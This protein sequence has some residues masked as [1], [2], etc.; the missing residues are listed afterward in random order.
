MNPNIIDLSCSMMFALC[1]A[2]HEVR[3]HGQVLGNTQK[4]VNGMSLHHLC[5]TSFL[6]LLMLELSKSTLLSPSSGSES[7]LLSKP[8]KLKWWVDF[9]LLL[10]WRTLKENESWHPSELTSNDLLH[11]LN[12]IHTVSLAKSHI[13]STITCWN[14]WLFTQQQSHLA[15]QS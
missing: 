10:E 12:Y 5:Y 13:V 9:S 11:I 8:D 4:D 14:C 15:M 6:L 1:G 3:K 2:L 7:S